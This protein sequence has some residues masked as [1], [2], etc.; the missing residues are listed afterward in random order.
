MAAAATASEGAYDRAQ[1]NYHAFTATTL[2]EQLQTAQLTVETAQSNLKAQQRLYDSNLWLYQQHALARKQLDQAEVALTAARTQYEMAKRHLDDLRSTGIKEQTNAA[3]GQL[4]LARGQHLAAQAQLQYSELR[5]PIDGMVADRSVYPGEMA[6]VGTPL[7]TIMDVSRVV[8]RV[9]VP[10]PAAALLHLG[11]PAT[12]Q[13]A[14]LPRG[15]PGKITVFSPALDPNST[16]VEL[17]V[18]ASNTGRHLEP[19]TACE[20]QITAKV[21]PHAL[22]IPSSALLTASDG[23]VSVMVVRPDSRAYHQRVTTGIQEKGLTQI[24]S[25]LQ[26][27][28]EIVATGAYGLPD[29]TKVSPQPASTS[30]ATG[31]SGT[32]S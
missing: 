32:Q 8:T 4:E 26:V 31:A 20:V 27:G 14:G 9:H 5:S 16:T 2:P 21:V 24:L 18:E 7:F 13:I 3:E 11:D 10:Q 30:S 23:T 15:I 1:A 19:G 29:K 25:G 22:V 28:E 12:I 6:A 17:W